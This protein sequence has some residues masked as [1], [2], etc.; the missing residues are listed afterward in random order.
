[1]IDR[2]QV[3][4][5]D[6]PDLAGRLLALRAFA[7]RV[8]TR[9]Y[10]LTNACNLRCKGCWFFAYDFD[11]RTREAR[12]P[13]SW[14][15]FAKEQAAQGTTAALLIGGEPALYPDRVAAFVEAMEFVTISS[16]GLRALPRA[17][18]ERVAIALSLFGGGPLDDALRAV[19]PSGR[20]FSGL[21]DTVLANYRDDPRAH[22]IYAITPD[23]PEHIEPTV[24]RIHDNGN[25]VTFNYYSPYG[26]G[27]RDPVAQDAEQRLLDEAL[28]VREAYPE[29]V[30][31]TPL[32][33][34]TI[35][36]GRTHWAAW[37]YDVCPSVSRSHPAHA[38]RLA[39]GHPVLPHFD[40]YAADQSTVNFCCASGECGECRDSQ[41]MF[42]WL[43]VSLP[44]FLESTAQLAEWIELAE[45][46]WRQFVWSPY[47]DA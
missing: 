9:E 39:N 6:E 34:R 35:V 7:R 23:A 8:R 40:A 5:R 16:N 43:L 38:Q 29:T 36:T 28:R 30:G 47:R 2:L 20:P 11:E 1:M 12:S 14:R 18:F 42:S 3:L 4:L 10:H 17:G 15:L 33:L 21:F 45:S 19:R 41:A 46:Y 25:R 13:E 26:A 22:F 44:H 32:Y 37:S 24:R 27:P 31:V